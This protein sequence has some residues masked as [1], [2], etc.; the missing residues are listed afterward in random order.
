MADFSLALI[1]L[2]LGATIAR[3]K[4]AKPHSLKLDLSDGQYPYLTEGHATDKSFRLIT[5]LPFRDIQATDWEIIEPIGL[6]AIELLRKAT[7]EAHKGYFDALGLQNEAEAAHYK[8]EVR[9]ARVSAMP[10]GA[11]PAQD[12]QGRRILPDMPEGSEAG[13]GT[14]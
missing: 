4:W 6:P 3:A 9:L 12:G 1:W 14:A 13:E 2:K 8:Q 10:Q 11:Q 5:V 7:E